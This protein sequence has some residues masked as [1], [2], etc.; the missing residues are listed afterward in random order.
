MRDR[1][2]VEVSRAWRYR[3]RRYAYTPPCA[4]QIAPDHVDSLPP[5]RR[6]GGQLGHVE[7]PD[8]ESAVAAAAEEFGAYL[9]P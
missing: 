4:F 2:G 1:S 6:Q 5:P 7:A 8:M 3:L 9:S